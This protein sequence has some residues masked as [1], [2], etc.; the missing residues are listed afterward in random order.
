M[1][2]DEDDLLLTFNTTNPTL[3]RTTNSQIIWT[4]RKATDA[5]NTMGQDAGTLSYKTIGGAV[6]GEFVAASYWSDYAACAVPLKSVTRGIVWCVGSVAGAD[7]NNAPIW[8][9]ALYELRLE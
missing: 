1:G 7:M 3:N 8:Y 5:P 4:G 6:G 9:T 2:T